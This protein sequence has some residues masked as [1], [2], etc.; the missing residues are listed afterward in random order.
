MFGRSGEKLIAKGG[1][2]FIA[3]REF[4]FVLDARIVRKNGSAAGSVAKKANDGGMS[5]AE[6]ADDAAFGA[7]RAGSSIEALN[8]GDDVVAV[9]GIF[10]GVA[11]D[12]EV[13][14][15]VGNGDVRNYEAVAVLMKNEA[16]LDFVAR[17]DFLLRE[18]LC[19]R[20]IRKGGRGGL[21]V[22]GLEAEAALRRLLYK[23]TFF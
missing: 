1:R 16:A 14:V 18:F 2:K 19:G 4:D 17:G 5:A 22:F 13:A 20:R 21:A 15:H 3:G 6:N 8:F 7:T 10:D 11:R 12:K 23:V 9:H